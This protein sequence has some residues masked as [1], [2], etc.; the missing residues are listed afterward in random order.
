MYVSPCM[1]RQNGCLVM[2]KRTACLPVCLLPTETVGGT[3]RM[4]SHCM[5]DRGL[6]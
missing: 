4:R 2:N 1:N 6:C 3:A 5:K